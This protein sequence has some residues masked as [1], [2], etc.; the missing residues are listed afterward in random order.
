MGW[1]I[2]VI[3]SKAKLDYK[4]DYLVVRTEEKTSRIHLSEISVLIIE[5]T[6]VSLTAY[7][8][9]ELSKKKVKVI[10]CDERCN[11]NSEL[12]CLHGSYDTSRKVRQQINWDGETKKIV[13]SEIVKCKIKG[14][15]SN[16]KEHYIEEREMLQGYLEAVEP[17]DVTNREGHAAKVYFNTLFGKDFSRGDDNITNSALN[18]GYG[19]LLSAFNREISASGYLTQLGIFHS[20]TFNQFNLS[21]DFMEPFRPFVDRL[22]LKLDLTKLDHNEKMKI[23]DILNQKIT[24][25]EQNHYIINAIHIYTMSVLEALEENDVS[26]IKNPSYEL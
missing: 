25:N 13:W 22:V 11:P 8:L 3:K 1:R 16:V 6:A 5:S 21:C 2:V 18:Y 24:I 14:Q 9:V 4:M 20:N 19:I 23:V 7:L 17:G 12:C 26:K 15:L 10:F